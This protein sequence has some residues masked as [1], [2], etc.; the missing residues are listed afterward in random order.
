MSQNE[1]TV[2]FFLRHLKVYFSKLLAELASYTLSYY[3]C[4]EHRLPIEQDCSDWDHLA[5]P[6]F[7]QIGARK[8]V[9]PSITTTTAF[10]SIF[11][12]TD[13]ESTFEVFK[14]TCIPNNICLIVIAGLQPSSSFR[15]DK[16]IVPLG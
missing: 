9:I 16:Q 3:S 15:M 6:V 14:R 12:F 4:K 2:S 1:A 10:R 11:K 8:V 7:K 5:N 13:Y